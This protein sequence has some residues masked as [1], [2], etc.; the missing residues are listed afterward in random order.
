M[1]KRERIQL[2]CDLR[3]QGLKPKQIAEIMGI[4][5]AGVTSM[6]SKGRK[7][8]PT[9]IIVSDSLAEENRQLKARVAQL[10]SEK[11]GMYEPSA[12]DDTNWDIWD[13]EYNRLQQLDRMI[14]VHSINDM[15]IPDEDEQC[16]NMDLEINAAVQPDITIFGG[17]MYDFDVLSLKYKRMYNRRRKDPFLEVEPRWND[18]VTTIKDNNPNGI[19]LATGDNH[20]Q[21]RMEKF[22]NEWIP[23]FG[24]RLTAD[25]NALVRC[26]GLVLWLGW[27]QEVYMQNTIFEHGKRAGAN[28]AMANFKFHGESFNDVAGHAHRWQQI[29]S[30][31]QMWLPEEH[32]MLYYPLTSVVTGCS[33]HVPPHYITDTKSANSTQGSAITHVN[34]HGLDSHV[35]NILYHPRVDGSL[36]AAFGTQV[37]KQEAAKATA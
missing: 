17:D 19:I 22:I 36:V 9:I 3:A 23:V 20:G 1:R 18:I 34:L 6:I 24:D 8:P 15:H 25:Y 14:V 13:K 28:P 26:N 30:V 33:Q 10:E 4:T 7:K 12:R 32:R 29:V 11:K 5:P 31:K 27:T 2:A 21:Q 16:I 35:Q 37:F